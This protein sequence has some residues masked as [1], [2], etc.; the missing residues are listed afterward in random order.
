MQKVS[1]YLDEKGLPAMGELITKTVVEA[2]CTNFNSLRS[3]GFVTVRLDYTEPEYQDIFADDNLIMYK[4]LN[5]QPTVS[6]VPTMTAQA[7]LQI[8]VPKP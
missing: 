8:Q 2:V 3:R 7:V 6:L 1:V 4:P 5:I